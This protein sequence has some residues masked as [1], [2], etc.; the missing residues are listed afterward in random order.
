MVALKKQNDCVYVCA[1]ACFHTCACAC[2]GQR[3]TV[4]VIPQEWH[5]LY[6]FKEESLTGTCSSLVFLFSKS[7][8]RRPFMPSHCDLILFDQ[9]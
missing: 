6:S 5:P 7:L 8:R 2:A 4:S 9:T 1:R 3:V